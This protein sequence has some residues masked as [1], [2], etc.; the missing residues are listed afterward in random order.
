[1]GWP[2]EASILMTCIAIPVANYLLM[3]R[4]VFVDANTSSP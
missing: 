1:M 4:A 2:P 3:A